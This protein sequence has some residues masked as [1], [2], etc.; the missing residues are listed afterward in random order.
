MFVVR[1][2]QRFNEALERFFGNREV[3]ADVRVSVALK[4]VAVIRQKTGVTGE[5]Y[6]F[7]FVCRN[8]EA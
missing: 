5:K 6:G 7:A 2:F 1:F 4:P 8:I 3:Y